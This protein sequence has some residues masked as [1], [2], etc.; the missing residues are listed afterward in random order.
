[1]IKFTLSGIIFPDGNLWKEQRKF[2]IKT[3]KHLGL[4]RNSLEHHIEAET[5]EV[6]KFL[7]DQVSSG[8]ADIRIDEF[9]DLPCLNVIWSL[10]NTSRFDYE[11]KHL[12]RMIELID[13]FTMNNFVGPL[14]IHIIFLIFYLS[15]FCQLRA[16]KISV[17]IP[18]LKY[19]PP[20]SFIYRG[21]K[22]HMDIFKSYIVKL[23]S[24]QKR[25]FDE[26]NL[27]SFYLYF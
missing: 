26:D 8:P 27:R 12:K 14:G 17:G 15:V 3:L 25:T 16:L 6:C 10:V 1:M 4:G 7:A 18:Y 13:K 23:V 5:V 20:F 19:L 9:F 22:K 24:D 11:D 2:A 21:I